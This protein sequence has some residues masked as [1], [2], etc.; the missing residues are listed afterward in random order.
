MRAQV[1]TGFGSSVDRLAERTLRVGSLGT[2]RRL[3]LWFGLIV[4]AMLAAD[5][6]IL[7]QLHKVQAETCSLLGSRRS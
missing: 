1:K 2:G 4:V 7:W 5:G 3:I 6:F